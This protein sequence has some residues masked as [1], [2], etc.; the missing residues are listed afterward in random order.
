MHEMKELLPICRK[1]EQELPAM[2]HEHQQIRQALHRLEL[3]AL[4][5]DHRHILKFVHDLKEHAVLEEKV[6]YPAA[7]L[8]GKYLEKL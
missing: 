1:L 7:I 5:E 4:E 3:A 2:L 8:V 6:L